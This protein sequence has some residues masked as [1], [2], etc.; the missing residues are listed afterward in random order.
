MEAD[1][2]VL[3]EAAADGYLRLFCEKHGADYSEA[4]R[5]WVGG[6]AGDACICGDCIVSFDDMRTDI[7][8]DAPPGEFSKYSEYFMRVS[9]LGLKSPNYRNWLLGAPRLPPKRIKS[10]MAAKNSLI[11]ARARYEAELR[12]V[13][14]DFSYP[15]G[16]E[17]KK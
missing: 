15:R 17:K 2:R 7:D 8:M 12:G 10:L 13:R 4:R 14:D 16:R 6:R 11:L 5:S 3:F 1:P 9:D